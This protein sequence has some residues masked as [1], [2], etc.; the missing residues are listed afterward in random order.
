[1]VKYKIFSIKKDSRKIYRILNHTIFIYGIPRRRNH[2][3]LVFTEGLTNL[4]LFIKDHLPGS[5]QF[6]WGFT[7]WEHLF[8]SLIPTYFTSVVTFGLCLW[9]LG[10]LKLDRKFFLWVLVI[11]VSTYVVRGIVV[12]PVNL[13]GSILILAISA[14]ILTKKEFAVCLFFSIIVVSSIMFVSLAATDNLVLTLAE[15]TSLLTKFTLLQI[16]EPLGG[17]LFLYVV[18]RAKSVQSL[19][20]MIR[21]MER[22]SSDEKMMSR[23]FTELVGLVFI[24]LSMALMVY[25]YKELDWKISPFELFIVGELLFSAIFLLLLF[26]LFSIFKRLSEQTLI[27]ERLTR[28]LAASEELTRT[29]RSQKH[30]FNNQL[31]AILHLAEMGRIDQLKAMILDYT[32]GKQDLPIKSSPLSPVF[33]ATISPFLETASSLGIS[34]YQE[35]ES[36]FNKIRCS[37]AILSRIM[38]NLLKNAIDAINEEG[39]YLGRWIKIKA[40]DSENGLVIKVANNGP[41]I[42]KTVLKNLFEVGFSTKK[43]EN[44]GYGLAIIKELLDEC[45]GT[46]D[47][48]SD[49]RNGTIFTVTF[50][51]ESAQKVV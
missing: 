19:L 1:M 49:K 34:V 36:D 48:V 9:L 30:D 43:G 7:F 28:E 46:I 21:N 27:Q 40:L 29:L 10:N 32:G 18:T 8:L 15:K 47:V 51:Y 39:C 44:R 17:L 13:I 14:K 31:Q 2:M 35:I 20:D 26:Q 12:V 33:F 42:K 50:P 5:S 38:M 4:L 16:F 25:I 3:D 23:V 22:K 6:L 11:S 41:V 24:Q 45:G 37:P